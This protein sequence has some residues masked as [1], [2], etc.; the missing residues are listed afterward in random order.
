MLYQLSATRWRALRRL[1][2]AGGSAPWSEIRDRMRK[3][4]D[5]Q[6]RAELEC[7]GLIVD[8]GKKVKLTARGRATQELGEVDAT[9]EELDLLA[10]VKPARW[11]KKG[12]TP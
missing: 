5:D 2:L 3:S 8:S 9:I 7:F 10:K 1:H 12:E 11:A 4:V 6:V